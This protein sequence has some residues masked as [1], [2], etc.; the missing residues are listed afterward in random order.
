MD[1]EIKNI[2]VY[3]Q[4]ANEFSN[5]RINRWFWIDDF[6]SKFNKKSLILDIGCGNG[7]NMTYPDLNFIGIDNCPNF[8]KICKDKNLNV[9]ESDMTEIPLLEN[10]FDGIISIASFHH[11]S[12]VE[13][14]IN[15]LL[16][17]KRMLKKNGKVL[18]SVWSIDQ[19]HNKKL[20]FT[21][22]NNY[23][24]WKN[25]DGTIKEQRYYY[26]FKLDELKSLI[27]KYFIIEKHFWN[28][29]NEIF[30]LKSN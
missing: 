19:H 8:I 30:I 5:S 9:M 18:L 22:G 16:E 17:M 14:R 4:I 6:L 3:N 13:R 2:E 21:Y 25:K 7:R 24:P 1:T 26:I 15:S 23:V 28:H 11:L 20:N 29:G 12:T 27:E 10:N